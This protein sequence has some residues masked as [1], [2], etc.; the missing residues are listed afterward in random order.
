MPLSIACT[1]EQQVPVTASPQTSSGRPAPIDGALR[2]SVVSGDGTFLQDPA[3]P[4]V[5]KAV[6]GDNPGDTI[7][8]VE[9]D[10]DMGGT[11]ALIQDLVTLTVTSAVAANFGFVAGP[12]EN[13]A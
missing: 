5:F 6:S 10:A 4:L 1:N 8:L 12:A 9:A 2:I 11:E 7:Y 13:K 3:T